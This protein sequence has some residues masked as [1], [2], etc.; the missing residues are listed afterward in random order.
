MNSRFA[1]C[2]AVMATF[3]LVGCGSTGGGMMGGG[4]PPP[5]EIR[6][7]L[8]VTPGRAVTANV[9]VP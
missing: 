1:G 3:L 4:S 5:V 9:T 2:I 6:T 8:T 7:P